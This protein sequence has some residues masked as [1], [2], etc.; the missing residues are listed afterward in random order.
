[1]ETVS[2]THSHAARALSPALDAPALDAPALD[3]LGDEIASLAAQIHAATYRLLCLIR[4]FDEAGGWGRAGCHRSKAR[5]CWLRSSA[6]RL[7]W[8]CSGSRRP[9]WTTATAG[10]PRP[11][12]PR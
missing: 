4:R 12:Q 10:A 7:S 2:L 1:M 8:F 9:R 11:V 3:A 5:W 6:P